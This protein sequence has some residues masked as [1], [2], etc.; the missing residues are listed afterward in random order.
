VGGDEEDP[1][2]LVRLLTESVSDEFEEVGEVSDSPCAPE[3]E[4]TAVAP[5]AEVATMAAMM[6]GWFFFLPPG[7]EREREI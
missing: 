5:M 6:D 4:A 3:V 7:K 2:E 1:I